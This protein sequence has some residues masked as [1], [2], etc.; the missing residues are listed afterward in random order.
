MISKEDIISIAKREKLPLGTVEKDFVLTY[1]LKKI[2]ES[3]LKDKMA[4]KGGTALHKM[5]LHK[6]ISID[7]DFTEIKTINIEELRKIVEDKEINSK[8]KEI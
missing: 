3:D 1:V 6:R 2:Y 8:I 7:L 5:Y 4:F